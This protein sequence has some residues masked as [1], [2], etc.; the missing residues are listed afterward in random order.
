MRQNT[1]ATSGFG[2]C[3]GGKHKTLGKQWTPVDTPKTPW[4]QDN[5]LGIPREVVLF[6]RAIFPSTRILGPWQNWVKKWKVSFF[7]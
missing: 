7:P 4:D 2:F 1:V 6:A 3:A 5:L